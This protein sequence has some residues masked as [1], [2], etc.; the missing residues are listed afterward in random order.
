M[1]AEIPL[2]S[3]VIPI[4]NTK[5]AF[6]EAA[7]LSIKQQTYRKY[8][9]IIIDDSTDEEVSNFTIDFVSNDDR[10]LY[11]HR[12]KSFGLGDALNFGLSKCSGKYIA[13]MDAD[14]ISKP[15]RLVK[16]VQ[17]LN[18]NIEISIL[19][20]GVSLVNEHN[21]LFGKK[22]YPLSNQKIKWE[23]NFRNA[24]A[25]PTVMFRSNIY[26]NGFNYSKK[27]KFCEDLELWLRLKKNKYEFANL[28]EKLLLFRES[29]IFIRGKD[30]R[31]YNLKARLMHFDILDIGSYISIII[32]LFHLIIPDNLR[33]KIYKI[34][35]ISN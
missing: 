34:F 35:L 3:V 12:K 6:L 17:F 33:A 16:Q 15:D 26:K 14:D 8:E 21:E 31:K 1:T 27:F 32:A 9:C 5:I 11:F 20:T 28:S 23:F 4:F 19:G 2:V 25:H 29:E 7:L 10:F 13:R 18:N 22:K 24:L 30:D